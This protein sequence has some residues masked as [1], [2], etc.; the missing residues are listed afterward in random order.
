MPID[1]YASCPGGTG[2]KIKFC[3]PD[4][5]GELEKIQRMIEGDQRAACLDHIESLEA[6]YPDRACLLSI[7]AML[8]AQA[9]QEEKSAATL[10]R[11]IEKYPDN[12]VALAEKAALLA[13]RGDC[14]AAVAVLQDALEKCVETLP[15]QA[16]DAIGLV[17]Q[18][19]AAEG[20]L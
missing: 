6:K 15:T 9:G 4:L 16:Y 17:G 10:A 19:L 20:Q 18:S 8:E 13:G 3:C 2:K 12:A 11:F 5:T 7:R 14:L 1:P